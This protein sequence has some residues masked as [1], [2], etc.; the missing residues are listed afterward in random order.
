[1]ADPLWLGIDLGTQSVRVLAVDDTGEV[2]GR[3][4]AP[5]TSRRDGPRHEQDPEK[6]WTAFVDACITALAGLDRARVA[7]LAVD[8]TSGTILLGDARGR[9]LTTGLMY[10]DARASAEAALVN[11]AGESVWGA[12]GYQRMQPSW[13]LPDLVWLL[14]HHRELA[15]RADVRL[16]H[17]ADL[18]TSRLAG[19]PVA[20]DASHA[21][22]TGYHLVDERWPT[23]VFDRLEIPMTLLPEVVPPGTV[24][25]HVGSDAASATGIP[26]GTPMVAGMTDG[27]AAQLGAGALETGAWNSVLGTTLVLKGVSDH[28][29]HDPAGV[30]YC[31][32]GPDSAWLPGGASS[33]GAGVLSHRFPE[34]DLDEFTARASERELGPVAY[35]L[36]SG[37]ER[38]PFRAPDA[39]PFVLGSPDD[40]TDLFGAL[41]LGVACVERLCLDYLDLLGAAT[42]GPLSFTGGAARNRYWC[43]LRADL[44]GRPVRL[45]EQAE[46]AFGMAVLA[47]TAGGRSVVDAADAMVR[48][49]A[50]VEPL[51]DR[52]AGLLDVYALFVDHLTDRGW[53]DADV[54]AH[55]RRRAER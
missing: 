52:A 55:A 15:A 30:V 11:E 49:S 18:I 19:H 41:L 50:E 28:L 16:F 5:L 33:S 47:A 20:T 32:R 34:A 26:A 53:L 54:A 12:L 14:R 1:M 6:W 42:D 44:L 9:P 45:P 40:D 37:G 51:V 31:H 23:E 43:Q 38:F 2:A 48:I 36:V 29:I 4:S 35:P 24:L 8:S 25:G 13:A 17:Q 3:G 46:A 7:G 21:L 22:K 39:Q 10:D 27:C